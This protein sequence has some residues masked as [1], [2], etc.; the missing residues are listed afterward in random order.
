MDRGIELL[1]DADAIIELTREGYDPVYGARP[2]K[3]VVQRRL[4]NP[5]ATAILDGHLVSGDVVEIGLVD[6][7]IVLRKVVGD[8]RRSID[9]VVH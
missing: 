5:L 1:L 9:S 3:R 4:E 7:A 2:M 6:E 8:D